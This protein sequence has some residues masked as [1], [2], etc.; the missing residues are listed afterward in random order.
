VDRAL[1]FVVEQGRMKF[2][3]PLYRWALQCSTKSVKPIYE[4]LIT[5]W[6]WFTYHLD[7]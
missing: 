6:T 1:D 3:R 5:D 4:K 2:I 7:L